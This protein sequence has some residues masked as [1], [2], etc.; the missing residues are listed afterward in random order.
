MPEHDDITVHGCQQMEEEESVDH[1]PLFFLLL[2]MTDY[3]PNFLSPWC[4]I[5]DIIVSRDPTVLHLAEEGWCEIRYVSFGK[6][7]ILHH[8]EI[9]HDYQARSSLANLLGNDMLIPN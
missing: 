2:L 4:V 1:K 8:F 6:Q 3:H 7:F 5:V 9:D